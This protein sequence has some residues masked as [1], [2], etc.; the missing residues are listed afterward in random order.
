MLSDSNARDMLVAVAQISA[1]ITKTQ[2]SLA[3]RIYVELNWI[4]ANSKE[5]VTRKNAVD[6]ATMVKYERRAADFTRHLDWLK[7]LPV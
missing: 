1:H 4:D 6:T 7:T 3:K 5:I 2:Y